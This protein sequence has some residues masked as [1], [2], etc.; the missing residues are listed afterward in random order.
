MVLYDQIF[1]S[2]NFLLS[3]ENAHLKNYF[4]VLAMSNKTSLFRVISK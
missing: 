3:M 4:H 2:P 1:V